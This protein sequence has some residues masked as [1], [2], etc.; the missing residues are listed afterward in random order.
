MKNITLFLA[1]IITLA[2]NAWCM[3]T[4]FK[5]GGWGL[6]EQTSLAR[7]ITAAVSLPGPGFV[8]C[9]ELDE[10]GYAKVHFDRPTTTQDLESTESHLRTSLV[11]S[12][13]SELDILNFNLEALK[14]YNP[15][16]RGSLLLIID[17][18]TG[19]FV[20]QTEAQKL[21]G[22]EALARSLLEFSQAFDLYFLALE[23]GPPQLVPLDPFNENG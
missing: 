2:H 7:R 1:A 5:L 18:E 9:F 21:R 14:P 23:M 10:N 20:P 4:L 16:V 12:E 13:L 19:L 6:D 17:P 11:L 22:E 3:P 15:D 8:S